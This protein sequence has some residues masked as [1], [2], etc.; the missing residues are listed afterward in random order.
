LKPSFRNRPNIGRSRM[1]RQ[2]LL[3]SRAEELN[4]A[5]RACLFGLIAAKSPLAQRSLSLAASPVIQS[6]NRRD[7][8]MRHELADDEWTTMQEDFDHLY[9]AL[10]KAGMRD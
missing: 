3:W 9:E 2:G 5:Q 8:I 1:D 7:R 10:H 6:P 4:R